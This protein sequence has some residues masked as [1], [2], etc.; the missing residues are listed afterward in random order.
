LV[1]LEGTNRDLMKAYIVAL[2]L[3][4]WTLESIATPLGKSRERVRQLEM[5]VL[6]P[7]DAPLDVKNA[8]LDVPVPPLKPVVVRVAKV[9]IEP[10]AEVVARLRELQPM[11]QSVRANGVKYR[12]EAEEYTELIND[13]NVRG[14]SLYRLAKELGITHAALRFRLVR[15]GYKTTESTAKVYQPIFDKNRSTI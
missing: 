9:R 10:Y 8:G 2:R 15:Y 13:E 4:G 7:A 14:V 12:A 11:A 6:Y 3:E 5:E 1:T